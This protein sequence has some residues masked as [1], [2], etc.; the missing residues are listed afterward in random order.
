MS[1]LKNVVILTSFEKMVLSVA[2]VFDLGLI[3]MFFMQKYEFFG[4]EFL[5]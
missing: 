5:F 2:L 1:C 3:F 4:L